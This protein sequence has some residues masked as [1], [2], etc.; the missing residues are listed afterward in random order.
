MSKAS[1]NSFDFKGLDRVDVAQQRDYEEHDTHGSEYVKKCKFASTA[2]N[3]LTRD[4][5]RE[6]LVYS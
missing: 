2:A 5:C 4:C 3:S 1:F 6:G